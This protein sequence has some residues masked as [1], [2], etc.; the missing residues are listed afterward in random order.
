MSEV[1]LEKKDTI[2]TVS[3]SRPDARNAYNP[4]MAKALYNTFVDI[5]ADPNIRAVLL[6]GEGAAFSVGGD[7]KFFVQEQDNLQDIVPDTMEVLNET[8]TLMLTL[9]QPIL[10]SVHGTVAGVGMSLMM[11]SDL[12]IAAASTK[13]TMA[14]A[15]IGL[16]AD[17]AATYLLPRIVGLAKAR[18]MLMLPELLTAEMLL[19]YG[20]LNWISEDDKFE[21]ATQNII[22]TLAQG[23]TRVFHRTKML[24]LNAMQMPLDDQLLKE[25]YAMLESIANRDFKIGVNSLLDRIDAKFEGR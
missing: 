11:A 5:N 7:I 15:T 4:D 19:E 9:K 24:L 14:Y 23:P 21:Q 16:S 22:T 8:I 12:C 3:L 10:A 20:L 6:K 2:A 13:F 17:G 18:Q 1:L 25:K